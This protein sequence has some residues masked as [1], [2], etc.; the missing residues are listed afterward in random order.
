MGSIRERMNQLSSYGGEEPSNSLPELAGQFFSLFRLR[1]LREEVSLYLEKHG[2][3]PLYH[4]LFLTVDS[5]LSLALQVLEEVKEPKDFTGDVPGI[6]KQTIYDRMG[7]PLVRYYTLRPIPSPE[8]FLTFY[9]NDL[10]HVIDFALMPIEQLMSERSSGV[11]L[12][13]RMAKLTQF[14]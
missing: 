10:R 8:G 1:W 9:G 7:T 4:G 5:N 2:R 13:E 6:F 14:S 12:A 11:S 3:F